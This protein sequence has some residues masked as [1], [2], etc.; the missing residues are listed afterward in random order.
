MGALLQ[1]DAADIFNPMKLT[2]AWQILGGVLI[3]AVVSVASVAI[4]VCTT[5]AFYN[6]GAAQPLD[7]TAEITLTV[8]F[9]YA[10]IMGMITGALISVFRLKLIFSV[11]LGVAAQCLVPALFVAF[12]SQTHQPGEGQL[13]EL[14]ALTALMFGIVGVFA[15]ASSSIFVQKVSKP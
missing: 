12:F 4:G 14:Y 5:R 6:T 11:I 10:G 8:F 1:L 2:R 9:V 7:T 15:G 13:F 3:G